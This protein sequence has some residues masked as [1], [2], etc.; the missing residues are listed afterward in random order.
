MARIGTYTRCPEDFLR[1]IPLD[2][3]EPELMN[4]PKN[5]VHKSG[6]DFLNL[7]RQQQSEALKVLKRLSN[8]VTF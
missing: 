7:V 6:T 3:Q 4:E 2:Y 5:Q 1:S 8:I